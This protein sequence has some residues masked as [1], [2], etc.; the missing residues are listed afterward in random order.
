[1][2]L[3]EWIINSRGLVVHCRDS[4]YICTLDDVTDEFLLAIYAERGEENCYRQIP[5]E[6]INVMWAEV[7]GRTFTM[8]GETIVIIYDPDTSEGELEGRF[9]A[10]RESRMDLKHRLLGLVIGWMDDREGPKPIFETPGF[11]ENMA[12]LLAIQ[13]TTMIG[14]G[15]DFQ[16]GLFG[17]IPVPNEI[18]F[19][20]LVYTYL[21][22]APNSTDP[23]M[24]EHGRP[25]FLF[26][27][28]QRGDIFAHSKAVHKQVFH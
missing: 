6:M 15:S 13:G 2:I 4:G 26:L 19:E 3:S 12:D 23:R 28:F 1:M 14:L 24:V 10:L 21:I 25:C 11:S 16:E 7:F 8:D 18:E 22:D 27:I 9:K 5:Q 20:A 17:P